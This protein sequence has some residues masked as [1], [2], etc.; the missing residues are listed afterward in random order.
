[1]AV[2]ERLSSSSSEEE[3]EDFAP[4]GRQPATAEPNPR[5]SNSLVVL[6]AGRGA[7]WEEMGWRGICQT[8][9]ERGGRAWL[10]I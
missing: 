7:V 8:E 2:K 9:L 6:D 3:E 4:C 1:M 10:A 5:V